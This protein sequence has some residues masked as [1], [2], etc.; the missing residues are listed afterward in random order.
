MPNLSFGG[1]TESIKKAIAGA[2]TAAV[3]V[4]AANGGIGAAL[5]GIGTAAAAVPVLPFVAVGAAAVGL[6]YLVKK[7]VEDG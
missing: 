6:G 7:A 3:A 4:V 5:A 2:G 1:N